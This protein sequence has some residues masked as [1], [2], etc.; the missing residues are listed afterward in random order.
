MFVFDAIEQARNPV[1][2]E[3][4]R[5]EEFS[6]VKNATGVDSPDTCREAQLLLAVDWLKQAGCKVPV[7]ARG[8]PLHPIEISPLFADSAQA[9]MVKKDLLRSLDFSKPLYLGA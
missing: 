1:V 7:D 8:L 4:L 2:I 9:L 6:A 5:R 3:T